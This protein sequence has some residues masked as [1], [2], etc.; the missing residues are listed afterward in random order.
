VNLLCEVCICQLVG[1][2]YMDNATMTWNGNA[3]AGKEG[4]LKFLEDIPECTHDVDGFD[5]QPV[6]SMSVT[7]NCIDKGNDFQNTCIAPCPCMVYKPL[8]S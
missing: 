3:V 1:K 7:W 6:A 2:L 5:A 8:Q 4:V